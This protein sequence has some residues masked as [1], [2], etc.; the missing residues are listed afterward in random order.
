MDMF[1][2]RADMKGRLD[3]LAMPALGVPGLAGGGQPGFAA[4]AAGEP[5]V[6]SRTDQTELL[7]RSIVGDIVPRLVISRRGA[8]PLIALP[9][10]TIA[11]TDVERFTGL[12]LSDTSPAVDAFVEGLRGR[13]MRA[14]DL[15]IDLLGPSARLLGDRW[16]DDTS[17]FSEITIAM[18][19]MRR[20][21]RELSPVFHAEVAPRPVN[22]RALLVPA[23]GEQHSLGLAIVTDFLRRAGWDVWSGVPDSRDGLMTILRRESFGLL[24]FST[25][26]DDRLES[27]ATAIRLARRASRNPS[28]G[29]MVGGSLFV[30]TP[31]MATL[32]GADAT[33][34]DGR[35]A[36]VQAENVLDLMLR[37][38]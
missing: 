16:E 9:S 36:A 33:A 30:Q 4:A 25:A 34:M 20:V 18:V 5:R 26:C 3:R 8:V 10:A 28:I 22:K 38:G 29:V 15:Y 17:T 21:L 35:H 24:G 11:A 1:D 6:L 23:P 37:R 7:A 19:G 14:D 31:E 13:G 12:L 27:L 2:Q 32:I